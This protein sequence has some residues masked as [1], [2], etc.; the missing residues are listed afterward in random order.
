MCKISSLRQIPVRKASE[1]GSLVGTTP[2][3]L[4]GSKGCAKCSGA[5]SSVMGALLLF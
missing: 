1:R 4:I 2:A 3:S 5:F